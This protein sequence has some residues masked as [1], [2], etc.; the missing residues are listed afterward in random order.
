MSPWETQEAK[1]NQW[2]LIKLK[3]FCTAKKTIN[4][5]KRPPTESEN[6]FANIV[7][8]KWL[9]S[10]I[11]KELIQLNI[12]K[13]KTLLKNGQNTWID[14]FPKKTDR[15]QVHEKMLNISTHQG[16]ANQNHSE[17]SPH[18]HQ[19]GYHQKDHK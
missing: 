16:N 11:Y 2:N 5:T 13:Q 3:S 7:S 6:R 19:D 17:V 10:K 14:I 15:Q 9:I 4:K 1:T 12:K 8:D 18:T